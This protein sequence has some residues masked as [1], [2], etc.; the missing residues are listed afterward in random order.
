MRHWWVIVVV[1]PVTSLLGCSSTPLHTA[2]LI[3]YKGLGSIYITAPAV[4]TTRTYKDGH[5]VVTEEPVYTETTT[6]YSDHT[7]TVYEPIQLDVEHNIPIVV[8]DS[9]G[10]LL[11]KV[12]AGLLKLFGV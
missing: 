7:V 2:P 4:I 6:T 3:R 1:L 9:G 11:E 12:I 5:K 10:S 8:E